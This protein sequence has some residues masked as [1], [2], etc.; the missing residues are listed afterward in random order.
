MSMSQNHGF[1]HD[2][3]IT[4][5]KPIITANDLTSLFKE[6]NKISSDA[7]NNEGGRRTRKNFATS[8]FAWASELQRDDTPLP[9]FNCVASEPSLKTGTRGSCGRNQCSNTVGKRACKKPSKAST[10]I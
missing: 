3:R 9:A 2:A 10:R 7:I 5:V 6:D 8:H 1:P 4:T